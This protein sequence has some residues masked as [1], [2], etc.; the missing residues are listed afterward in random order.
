MSDMFL[1]ILDDEEISTSVN[2][3][4][5]TACIG[6][7]DGMHLGHQELLKRTYAFGNKKYTVVTFVEIPQKTLIN[8]EYK[9][10]TS[11]S[12]KESLIKDHKATSILYFN[13]LNIKDMDPK[14]FCTLLN[15]KYGIKKIVVGNDFKFGKDRLGD[16]NFLSKFFGKNNVTIVPKKKVNGME[17][18]AS[19]IRE[20]ISNGKI[21]LV[22]K[23]LGRSYCLEGEVIEGNGLGRKIGF[24]T[25]N[26]KVNKN[27]R[28]PKNGVY[29]VRIKISHLSNI[30][31]GMINIGNRPTVSNSEKINV[32][33]NIFDF[34]TNIYG[35]NLIVDFISFLREEVKF[36]N[37]EE[38]KHQL[39]IDKQIS[40]KKL[41]SLH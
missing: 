19:L 3:E 32:E 28:I 35:S 22:S 27:Y 15:K 1:I 8:G 17:V 31:F 41:K 38:L 33:V 2:L 13:F 37:I 16:T 26:I 20:H 18:S 9:F 34:D 36:N 23:F 10:L 21:E 5:D 25:A 40:I 11:N 4:S 29:I 24:P 30:Y 14:S 39:N 7:F 12:L 6:T